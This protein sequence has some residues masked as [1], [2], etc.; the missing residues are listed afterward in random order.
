MTTVPSSQPFQGWSLEERDTRL[1]QDLLPKWQLAYRYY[2]RVKTEGWHNIPTQGNALYVGSHNG[3]L[4]SPDLLMFMVDWFQRFGVETPI[5]GLMHPK[6]WLGNPPV[7]KLATQ[8]G[9]LQ[10]H[11]KMAVA[12]LQSGAN[13]LVYPGGAEDVF[14]LHRHRQKIHL[15][16]RKGFIKLALREQVPIVPLVSWGA[17]DTLIVL[18]DC[19]EQAK[20]L[21]QRGL[22]PWLLGLDP[23]VFPIYLG[24][25]WGLAFGPLPNIPMP[26]QI[27]TK[28][29]K[30]IQ[31]DRYGREA[32]KDGVYVDACY[33]RVVSEMQDDLNALAL[34]S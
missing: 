27:K 13:V 15:A 7:S 10:A 1:I 29:C 14:R 30:P 28:V 26:V 2:F 12:A 4:A 19:Y 18:A 6:I 22:F 11:P 33:D 9:A 23:M 3:G 16:G 8:L 20:T 17:H 5:Y 24:L 32:A 31:F 25:P 21:N 34:S